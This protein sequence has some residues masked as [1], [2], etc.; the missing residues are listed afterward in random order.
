MMKI[1]VKLYAALRL[2]LG[3]ADV[4]IETDKQLNMLELLKKVSELVGE[5]ILPELIENGKIMVGTM[6][7]IDGKNVLHAQKLETPVPD[8]SIVSVFPPNGGG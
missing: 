2:N 6:L 3:I 5:D 4:F 1:H 7:L 8:G